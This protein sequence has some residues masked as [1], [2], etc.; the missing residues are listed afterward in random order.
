M[1]IKKHCPNCGNEISYENEFCTECG[2]DLINGTP[3][4]KTDVSNGFFDNL[5][6]KANIPVIIFSFVIF[7]IFLF[8]DS[9]IWSSFMKN[10][11]IGFSTYLLLTLIFSVFFASIFVGYFA[12]RDKSYVVPNFLVYIAS[13]YAV[14][15]SIYGL[16]FTFLM[17]FMSVLSS[18]SPLGSGSSSTGASSASNIASSMDLSFI[19]EI[20]LFILLIPVVSYAGIYLGYYFK[21]I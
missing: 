8:I 6:Q 1:P 9:F 7:G 3:S 19:F 12:C 11:S 13:I 4:P 16:L 17:G 20:I 21:D 18:I 5:P 10:G 2:Y 15:F 14:I